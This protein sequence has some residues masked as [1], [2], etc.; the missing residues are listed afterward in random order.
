MT[1]LTPRCSIT[2]CKASATTLNNL[3]AD[4]RP[5]GSILSTKIRPFQHM[6]SM[7]RSAGW[8][9]KSLNAFLTSSFASFAPFPNCRTWWT[10]SSTEQYDKLQSS[11][12]MPSLTLCWS[13]EDKSMISL[14]F[15]GDDFF[16]ITPNGLICS[17]GILVSF[18]ASTTLPSVTSLAKY[19]S[20]T[21]GLACA[22]NKFFL[23]GLQKWLLRSKPILKPFLRPCMRYWTNSLSG[24][25]ANARSHA[26]IFSGVDISL[27]LWSGGLMGLYPSSASRCAVYW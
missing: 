15:P 3:G 4:L 9:G 26:M 1:K 5:N 11:F 10:A 13:G 25:S 27:T 12:G 6:P 23:A 19:S 8:T 20:T 17:P 22:E 18:V 2:H 16:G 24:W 21:W 7:G 14:Q